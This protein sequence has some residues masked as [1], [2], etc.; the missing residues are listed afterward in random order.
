MNVATFFHHAQ[1]F[2]LL[3]S[4]SILASCASVPAVSQGAHSAF[5][6]D[7]E[8]P[9]V[10][11]TL[12][13]IVSTPPGAGL[14][15]WCTRLIDVATGKSECVDSRDGAA[16]TI[17]SAPYDN[18][19]QVIKLTFALRGGSASAFALHH[20]DVATGQQTEIAQ[21]EQSSPL[22]TTFEK[23]LSVSPNGH[24]L[25]LIRVAPLRRDAGLRFT[26]GPLELFDLKTQLW[27]STGV[28]AMDGRP[29]QWLD[30]H[31]IVYV[32]VTPR[33]RVDE[34]ILRSATSQP[35]GFAA[36]YE[37]FGRVPLVVLRD[38]QTGS[39]RV[40]HIGETA[41][42]VPGSD[43]IV[44]QDNARHLRFVDLGDLRSETLPNDQ[45][46]GITHKGVVAMLDRSHLLYW[47]LPTEGQPPRYTLSNS[48]LVG[49]KLVL[50][51]KVADIGTREFVT[52]VEH[53]D[54]R[55]HPGVAFIH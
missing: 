4:V 18:G 37:H 32:R 42:V 16:P 49:P 25:A 2:A 35:D 43:R 47:A 21:W 13:A 54:P 29:V 40:L 1:L 53:I 33:D 31:K 14:P 44:V 22:A 9:S 52:V 5:V 28:Q 12:K 38:L 55:S 45:L 48:P 8:T 41:F 39:E 30:D 7:L 34:A 50:S 36:A 23:T 11:T 26:Q 27:R 17:F 15:Q 20:L 19:N 46:P 6:P 3:A 24:R 10:R 51:L